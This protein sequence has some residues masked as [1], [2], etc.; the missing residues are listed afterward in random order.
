M[1]DQINYQSDQ[2]PDPFDDP[3]KLI[4]YSE[5]IDEYGII[6]HDGGSSAI[7]IKY[8][9]WCGKKLPKSKRDLW[10]ARLR[11]LGYDDPLIENIPNEFQTDEWYRNKN[12]NK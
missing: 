11:K 4:Y 10:F 12:M 8:C 6:I 1:R 7:T 5:K 2:H 9:P 3:D